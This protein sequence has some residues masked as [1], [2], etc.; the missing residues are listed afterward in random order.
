MIKV[1]MC[2]TSV[3]SVLSLKHFVIGQATAF[4]DPLLIIIVCHGVFVAV[5]VA[6]CT[7]L[8][9]GSH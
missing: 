3:P 8:H 4:L 6:T 5:V 7:H 2:T 1:S 9:V